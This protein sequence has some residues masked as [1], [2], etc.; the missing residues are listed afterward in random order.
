M[1]EAGTAETGTFEVI[2]REWH[3]R[4]LPAWSESRATGTLARLEKDCIPLP[5]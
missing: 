4:Q 2:A 5:W 1:K 3:T